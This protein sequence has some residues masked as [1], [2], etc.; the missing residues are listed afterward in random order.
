MPLKYYTKQWFPV[1][2]NLTC[3]QAF[4][5]VWRPFHLSW[6]DG[7]DA[8]G[9]WWAEARDAAEHPIML[10]TALPSTRKG[11][12]AQNVYGAKV[13]NLILR[14]HI[15][16]SSSP[17]HPFQLFL[18]GQGNIGLYVI[19]ILVLFIILIRRDQRQCF[20]FYFLYKFSIAAM[21]NYCHTLSHLKQHIYCLKSRHNRAQ[22]I[23]CLESHRAEINMLARLHFFLEVLEMNPF[24]SLFR[25]W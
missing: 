20:G 6:V 1:R 10:R 25:H 12:L 24:P 5:S 13:R 8:I 19:S 21:T 11:L 14:M 4:A 16:Q 2:G 3:P 23:L 17:S 22:L 15:K 18:T 7:E 9:I